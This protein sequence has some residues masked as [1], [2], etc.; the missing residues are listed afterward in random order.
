MGRT[1]PSTFSS[2]WINYILIF[3]DSKIT[4]KPKKSTVLKTLNSLLSS[5]QLHTRHSCINTA[6]TTIHTILLSIIKTEQQQVVYFFLMS[7]FL[8]PHMATKFMLLRGLT[9]Q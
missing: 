5:S 1:T 7:S 3:Y 2:G 9:S 6:V 4:T 8:A